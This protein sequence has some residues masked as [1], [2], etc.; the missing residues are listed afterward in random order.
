MKDNFVAI[1]EFPV[2]RKNMCQFLGKVNFY[3]K[4]IPQTY[5][6]LEPFHRLLRKQI[7]TQSSKHFVHGCLVQGSGGSLEKQPNGEIKSVA[8]FSRKLREVQKKK[9][10]YIE[11]LAVMKAIKYWHFWLIGLSFEVIKDLN[12]HS[13]SCTQQIL[14][15]SSKRWYKH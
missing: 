2:P 6:T 11:I 3:H 5:K 8:Y 15:K 12:L 4:F 13:A 14:R 10:I 9:V 7:L 1:K